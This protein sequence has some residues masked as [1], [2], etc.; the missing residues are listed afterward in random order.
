M[1]ECGSEGERER[2]GGG[3]GD[4]SQ[5]ARRENCPEAHSEFAVLY[6]LFKSKKLRFLCFE[7]DFNE[8][9]SSSSSET[10]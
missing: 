3:D 1:K 10:P 9:Y 7:S 4:E 2:G 8:F 5:F 6:D